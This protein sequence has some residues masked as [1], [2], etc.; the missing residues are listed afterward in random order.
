MSPS[1]RHARSKSIKKGREGGLFYLL[2][3]CS[4]HMPLFQ[5]FDVRD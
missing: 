4:L 1:V 5:V 3:T 2:Y